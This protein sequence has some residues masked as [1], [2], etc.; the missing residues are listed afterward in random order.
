ML[1]H[2]PAKPLAVHGGPAVDVQELLDA[3]DRCLNPHVGLLPH[4]SYAL[5]QL[6]AVREIVYLV[7][8]AFHLALLEA[9]RVVDIVELEGEG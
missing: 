1:L 4:L 7:D 6:V 3:I 2:I 5:R 8:D 9:A